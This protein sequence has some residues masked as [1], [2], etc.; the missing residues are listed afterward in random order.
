MEPDANLKKAS[1]NA[2]GLGLP[3]GFRR[4][5]RIWLVS[6][7]ATAVGTMPSAHAWHQTRKLAIPP[8]ES[9]K[10]LRRSLRDLLP[11]G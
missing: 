8:G 10:Q 2:I 6:T 4:G 1:S 11:P 5:R 3:F 9:T 7:W